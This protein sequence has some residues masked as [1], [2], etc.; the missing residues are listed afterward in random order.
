MCQNAK[1]I[2]RARSLLLVLLTAVPVANAQAQA[3]AALL[4]AVTNSVAITSASRQF[5]VHGDP[6]LPK[7]SSQIT[8]GWTRLTS[9]GDGEL[10]ELEPRSLAVTCERI[11]T[12]VLS[13]LELQDVWRGRIHLFVG[14]IPRN[15]QPFR[16][17][18]D[19]YLD[20]WQYRLYVPRKFSW[21]GLVRGISEAL[22]LEIVNRNNRGAFGQAPLWFNEG[23]SGLL[24]N[25]HGRSFI[26]EAYTY[27]I[28][29]ERK[30]DPL[31][32][33]REQLRDREP[34][35]FADLGFPDAG[36][37]Q[38]PAEWRRYQAGAQLLVHELQSHR[39]TRGILNAMLPLLPNHLNFHTAFLEAS[40]ER[41][42]SLLEVEKWWA[43][44]SADFRF[45][46]P[47]T[48]WQREKILA[49]LASVLVEPTAT[50][51]G[52]SQTARGDIALTELIRTWE[53]RLQEEVLRRKVLQLRI[54]AS[55]APKPLFGLIMNYSRTLEQY[56]AARS[57][58]GKDSPSRGTVETRTQFIARQTIQ[59][60]TSLDQQR[61][62]L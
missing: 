47:S 48:L 49:S 33:A 34:P 7:S 11:K 61:R 44:A 30:P 36:R 52:T 51:I 58:A 46:D 31:A 60:L 2:R 25:E 10:I 50:S 38:D 28:Q 42:L 43:L 53:F 1:W 16:I 26:T 13:R 41:F 9:Q 56:L 17:L 35:S 39:E 5:M 62:A 59:R 4:W 40:R 8:P 18:P 37:L 3:Q 15:E 27:R 14:P 23:I 21:K 19:Q 29:S 24:L 20:G 57:G 12:A 6:E 55:H 22:I 54:L 45:R 32:F